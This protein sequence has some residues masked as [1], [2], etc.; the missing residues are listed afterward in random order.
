MQR[1]PGS[2]CHSWATGQLG[3]KGVIA[4][5]THLIM[6]IG[7]VCDPAP[8]VQVGVVTLSLSATHLF[9]CKWLHHRNKCPSLSPRSY[10][11]GR[12]TVKHWADREHKPLGPFLPRPG[13]GVGSGDALQP[14]PQRATLSLT[15]SAAR[16]FVRSSLSPGVRTHGLQKPSDLQDGKRKPRTENVSRATG[17]NSDLA[18]APG[19]G[20]GKG[21]GY[22][23]R[24]E[25]EGAQGRAG[26]RRSSGSVGGR[27]GARVET[28]RVRIRADRYPG[29]AGCGQRMREGEL[30]GLCA[31]SALSVVSMAGRPLRCRSPALSSPGRPSHPGRPRSA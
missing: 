9:S 12:R 16:G 4:V 11:K 29:C 23:A 28:A 2:F 7:K 13:L 10:P 17:L 14:D 30:A 15:A 20:Q 31:L 27:H 18:R 8:L 25:V 3:R 6:E 22:R 21:G 24:A 19:T 5:T 26:A 1:L